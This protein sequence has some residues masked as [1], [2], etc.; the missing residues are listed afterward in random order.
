MVVHG[1]AKRGFK[2]SLGKYILPSLC[3]GCAACV[4]VCPVE[5]LEY[6][7]GKP[8][9]SGE[10]IS[11]G[12][13]S[14]VCP[15]YGSPAKEME[16]AFF[17]RERTMDEE[18]GIYRRVTIARTRNDD[19][20]RVCQD[21]GVVTSLLLYAFEEGII[22]GAI[23]SGRNEESPLK[24][25]P[26]LAE[27]AE[28]IIRSA[29]TR[30]TYSPN[31]L[32]LKD[33]VARGKRSIGFVG[34]PCQIQAIRKIQAAS[35]RRYGEI[36]NFTIGIFCSGCFSYNGLVN[37]LIRKKMGIN[38]EDVEKVNIKGELIVKTLNEG[39]KTIS[40]KE[41][42]RY[43]S[44]CVSSCM[45][46]SAELAD[47]SAGGLGLEGWTL[48]ILRSEKGE[49]LFDGAVSKGLLEAKSVSKDSGLWKMLVRLS[50]RKRRRFV[51]NI[52][53]F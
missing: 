30:Y 17:G 32:L 28:E 35:L 8:I 6:V 10:C 43:L 14:S 21:G 15:K 20:Q 24:A 47:I 13:C 48:T 46:F 19:I 51:K 9:L 11:C 26:K 18:F 12:I 36:V 50:R 39:A 2:E 34:T 52:T 40:L 3:I 37:E 42:K 31:I 44:G 23:V 53:H 4:A 7:D 1:L 5:C 22:D 29:G 25:Y 38:P 16:K 33:A 49:A 27:S 45:D 41:A